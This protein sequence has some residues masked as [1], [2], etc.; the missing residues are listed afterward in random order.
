MNK[1][2]FDLI[3]FDIR[4]DVRQQRAIHG[5]EDEV[6]F[7]RKLSP[8]H[9]VHPHPRTFR[10]VVV[11]VVARGEN[12]IHGGKMDTGSMHRG[13]KRKRYVVLRLGKFHCGNVAG[14][15]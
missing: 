14:A 11:Y 12:T 10:R 5:H 3:C 15:G 13:S 1:D 7:T 6:N 9:P 4:H 8:P 2:Y